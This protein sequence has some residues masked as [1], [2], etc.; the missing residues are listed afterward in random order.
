MWAANEEK[1]KTPPVEKLWLI[2]GSEIDDDNDDDDA[3]QIRGW[4]LERGAKG[5]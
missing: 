3:E 2:R 5:E 1:R 4:G